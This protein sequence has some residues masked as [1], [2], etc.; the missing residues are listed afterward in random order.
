[1]HKTDSAEDQP[2]PAELL[3]AKL[4]EF[5]PKLDRLMAILTEAEEIEQE[6]QLRSRGG[7]G[8]E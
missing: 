2:S 8:T 1:M 7:N 5:E 4:I 6:D 3:Y